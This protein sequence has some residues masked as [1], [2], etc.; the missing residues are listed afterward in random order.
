MRH[1]VIGIS[2]L[3]VALG[4]VGCGGSSATPT[5]SS[6][7]G[8]QATSPPTTITTP[9]T[10]AAATTPAVSATGTV[11][12]G[13]VASSSDQTAL[14]T[15]SDA[16]VQNLRDQSHD[17][18][19][20]LTGDQQRLRDLTS[21]QLQQQLTDQDLQ[22]LTTCVPD[23]ATVSVINRTVSVNGDTATV[24]VTLEMTAADGTKSTVDR[25]LQ[26]VQQSDG[27]WKLNALP[28]CPFSTS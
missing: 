18:L 7:S 11:V 24:T 23:G 6:V 8:S 21:D 1:L 9:A 3:V 14:V 5:A 17:R 19:Q 4:I 20:D 10:Q 27:T 28:E 13:T 22:R 26:F 12:T 16:F 25:V 2:A 15:V